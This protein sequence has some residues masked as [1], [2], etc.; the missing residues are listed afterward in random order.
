MISLWVAWVGV[1]WK[2]ARNAV[3]RLVRAR[4]DAA[5]EARRRF[6]DVID[7]PLLIPNSAAVPWWPGGGDRVPGTH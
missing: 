6:N 3:L 2:R 4:E 7:L 5:H 1:K